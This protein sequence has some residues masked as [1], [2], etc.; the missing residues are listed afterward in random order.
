MK[1]LLCI[2]GIFLILTWL[3]VPKASTTDLEWTIKKELDLKAPTLDISQSEDGQWI[4]IL[5]PGEILIYSNPEDKVMNRIP[6]DKAFD[7]VIHYESN[8]TLVLT[9]SRKSILKIIQL[10]AIE[11]I[12]ILGSPFK[13]PGDGP[14]TIAVFADYQCP[15]CARLEPLIDQILNKHPQ[16]VKLVY[17]HFPIASHKFAKKASQA[18]LSAGIQGKFWEFHTRLFENFKNL[19]D[20]KIQEIAKE[21]TLDM[22]K[23]NKDMESPEINRLIMRDISNAKEAG[24]TGIPTIFI[25]GRRVKNRSIEIIEAMI[26]EELDK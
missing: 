8:N 20:T 26:K 9:S 2:F 16:N 7:R 11:K 14:V 17:K 25:N 15:Y 23:L 6:V 13:G 10:E 5:S 22:E 19:D 24:V 12:D 4:F 21:L 3:F 1:K 18:A